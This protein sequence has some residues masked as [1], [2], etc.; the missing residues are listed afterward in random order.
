MTVIIV[1]NWIGIE[2]S[3]LEEVVPVSLWLHAVWERM[4]SSVLH[5]LW[6]NSPG[7]GLFKLDTET[8]CRISNHWAN[9]EKVEDIYINMIYVFIL[10]QRRLC[11]VRIHAWGT[12][13]VCLSDPQ[14][15]PFA[16][17][18]IGSF[19]F[20]RAT[21]RSLPSVQNYTTYIVFSNPMRKYEYPLR[22]RSFL[23]MAGYLNLYT[24]FF[25]RQFVDLIRERKY[26]PCY[27]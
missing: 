14:V 24:S 13:H 26:L 17:E 3:I 5:Q 27:S 18:T 21:S 6:V 25:F 19:P 1:G 2:T 8:S 15:S 9:N 4:K 7:D 10:R 12:W 16:W 11:E 22:P 20:S 23:F